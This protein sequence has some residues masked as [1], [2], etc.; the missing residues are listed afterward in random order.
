MTQRVGSGDPNIQV[1][2]VEQRIAQRRDGAGV[3]D[4]AQ[5]VRRGGAHLGIGVGTQGTHQG[6]NRCSR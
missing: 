5:G 6:V 2:V 3:L 4:L 1:I